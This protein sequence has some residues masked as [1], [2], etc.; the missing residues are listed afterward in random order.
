MQMVCWR[1]YH[2]VIDTVLFD[3]LRDRTSTAGTAL[4][5]VVAMAQSSDNCATGPANMTITRASD[6]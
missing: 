1:T 5:G 6:R 3:N 2:Q 4:G